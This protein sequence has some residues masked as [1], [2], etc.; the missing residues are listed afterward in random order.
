MLSF[1]YRT[2]FWLAAAAAGLALLG[3]ERFA[4]VLTAV[5]GV[6]LL[7]SYGAWRLAL[8]S[9]RKAARGDADAVEPGQLD[10]LAL[11]EIA[12]R[13]SQAIAGSRGFEA[14][15]HA[16][17]GTLRAELGSRETTVHRVLAIEPP[18]AHLATLVEGQA[19][20]IGVEHRVRLER[21]P[22]GEA[23]RERRVAAPASGRSRSR[24]C[25]RKRRWP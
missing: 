17:A 11:L 7:L 9:D 23:L 16:V 18:L 24:C 3:P 12:T 5:A 25:V 21:S 15:L 8:A 4:T 2:L 14:A 6:G 13:L 10:E 1:L 19:G 20:G 22:L